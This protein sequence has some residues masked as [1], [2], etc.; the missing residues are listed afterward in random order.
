LVPKA[1]ASDDVAVAAALGAL[2]VC[3]G[4]PAFLLLARACERTRRRVLAAT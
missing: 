2:D 3:G 4:A 1:S